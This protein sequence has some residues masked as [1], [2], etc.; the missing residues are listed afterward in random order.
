MKRLTRFLA[1]ALFCPLITWA[2]ITESQVFEWW[3]DG[4]ITAE[5]ADEMLQLLE[6]GNEAEACMLAEVYAQEECENNAEFR[7]LN[8]ELGAGG[9]QQ[10]KT[11]RGKSRKRPPL[12]PHGYALTKIRMDS[13]GRVKSHREELQIA[14]Y[15]YTL[16]LGSQEL[17]AYKNAGSE[18]YLGQIST[19]ELH[20]HIP[21]D[22]L[23]GTAL[24][25]PFGRFHLAG[26]LDT[27]RTLQ[28][29]A[30]FDIGQ[31]F[32][33]E[34][35]F[36][37]HP[38]RESGGL[39]LQLPFGQISGWQQAGQNFPLI[40]IQLRQQDSRAVPRKT[41]T[42]PRAV[43]SPTNTAK[44]DAAANAASPA[45]TT[46]P[47]HLFFSWRTT[48]YIHSDS[49]P[50]ESHLSTSILKNKLWA[51]QNVALAIPEFLDSRFSVNTR[52]LMP[53]DA[54]TISARVKSA[55]EIGPEILHG[56][57]EITCL[58]AS[59]NCPQIDYKTAITS[60]IPLTAAASST[61]AASATGA[62]MYSPAIGPATNSSATLSPAAGSVQN[63][64]LNGSIKIRHERMESR[65][66][67]P[68]LELGA[69]F[70]EGS[71]LAKI[72]FI[73]PK[74]KPLEDLQIRS[75]ARFASDI[76][77]F[78]LS[79]TFKKTDSGNFRPAHGATSAKISF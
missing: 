67:R 34:A 64:L 11:S 52:I 66:N 7:M 23:W 44:P 72:T 32:S 57:E 76:F 40:K 31:K 9:K 12:T 75:D 58:E 41:R 54:D 22:T 24:L 68:R 78:T 39:T 50:E 29:R 79:V 59:L 65:W 15:R 38:E 45:G 20:S 28:G 77:S 8:A 27:S 71:G 48:A 25:Y 26:L 16:R 33:A 37:K 53:L 55:L 74:A 6:D 60:A 42:A 62:A 46:M 21:L 63:L 69:G 35:F 18:A 70:Q 3:D 30:G 56:K 4:I 13:S 49:V 1:L 51:S 17:L 2:G 5:E 73:S 10:K 61:T 14:F 36:W 19:R 43:P 47:T